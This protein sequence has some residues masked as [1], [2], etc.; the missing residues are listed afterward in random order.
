MM[1]RTIFVATKSLLYTAGTDYGRN[2]KIGGETGHL[3]FWSL[4]FPKNPE[5]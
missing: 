4:K 3:I 1:C 2:F 5:P